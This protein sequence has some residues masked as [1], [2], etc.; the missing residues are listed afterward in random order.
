MQTCET[1]LDYFGARY[2]SGAQGRWTSPDPFNIILD[3]ESREQFDAY[4]AG[5]AAELAELGDR[6]EVYSS[7]ITDGA[8]R[9][10]KTV[11]GCLRSA[12]DPWKLRKEEVYQGAAAL[13]A[14]TEYE[15]DTAVLEN[16]GGGALPGYDATVSTYRGNVTR[17]RN[18]LDSGR[19]VVEERR[20]DVFGNPVTAMDGRGYSTAIA[21]GAGYNYGFPTLATRPTS[22]GNPVPLSTE[23]AYD[24]YLGQA[25]E[26]VE[27]A[28]GVQ[29]VKTELGYGNGG[30]DVLDRL[31][32]V[33]QGVGSEAESHINYRYN[34]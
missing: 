11:C 34:D 18:Y 2:F 30:A 28:A 16:Y 4:L 10:K 20:Y 7:P 5:S 25:T 32:R 33:I 14:R 1:G 19:E 6:R 27:K 15:H 31:S 23:T 26:V 12:I 17:V 22:A 24:V 29:V 3:A 21:Y 8:K 13:A 9:A